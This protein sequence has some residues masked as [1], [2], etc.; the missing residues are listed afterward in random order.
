VELVGCNCVSFV[1]LKGNW[2]EFNFCLVLTA[3]IYICLKL[4]QFLFSKWY[5]LL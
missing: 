1:S 5:S 3:Y 4:I 2:G